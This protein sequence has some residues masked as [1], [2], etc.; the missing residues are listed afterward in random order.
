MV[1]HFRLLL[2][3]QNEQTEKNKATDDQFLGIQVKPMSS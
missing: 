1:M 3:K 2:T